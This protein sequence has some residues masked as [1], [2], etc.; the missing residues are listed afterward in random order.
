M[1]I[2]TYKTVSMTAM[3]QRS[4]RVNVYNTALSLRMY[5]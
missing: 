1:D 4:P 3:Q 5:L 2:M